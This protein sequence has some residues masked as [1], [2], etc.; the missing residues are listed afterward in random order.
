MGENVLGISESQIGSAR[1]D[2]WG[3]AAKLLLK[4]N[5]E[6]VYVRGTFCF[7]NACFLAVVGFLGA[8]GGV[9]YLGQRSRVAAR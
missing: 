8:G 6:V 3:G 7:P 4:R 2:A 5:V 9:C 1:P